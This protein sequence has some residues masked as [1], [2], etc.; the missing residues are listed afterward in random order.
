ME[1]ERRTRS[2]NSI[3]AVLREPALLEAID[4]LKG[5]RNGSAGPGPLARLCLSGGNGFESEGRSTAGGGCATNT[6]AGSC[7]GD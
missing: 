1:T 4:R 6:K 3:R 7:S 5:S 2:G